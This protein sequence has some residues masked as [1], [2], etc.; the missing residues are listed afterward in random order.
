M[1][2]CRVEADH[3]KAT[4]VDVADATVSW[5]HDKVLTRDPLVDVARHDLDGRRGAVRH[6]PTVSDPTADKRFEPIELRRATIVVGNARSRDGARR[7]FRC[8]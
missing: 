3:F 8:W 2:G 1:P 4:N 5:M 7:F 6:G